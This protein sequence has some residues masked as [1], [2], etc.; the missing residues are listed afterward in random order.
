MT[1]KWV[2]VERVDLNI[3]SKTS[4]EKELLARAGK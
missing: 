3:L 2:R 4:V 1:G